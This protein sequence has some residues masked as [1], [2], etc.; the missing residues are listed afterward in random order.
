[1]EEL[2]TLEEVKKYLKIGEEYT[3]E[4][5]LIRAFI[6]A[7]IVNVEHYIERPISELSTVGIKKKEEIEEGENPY[8]ITPVLPANVKLAVFL[9]VSDWYEYRNDSMTISLTRFPRG[10]EYLLNPFKLYNPNP[11]KHHHLPEGTLPVFL[12]IDEIK[13]LKEQLSKEEEGDTDNTEEGEEDANG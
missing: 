4:D 13:K 9:L 11:K 8:E 12:T 5:D 6:Q 2:I 1:M 3:E 10:V 7:A